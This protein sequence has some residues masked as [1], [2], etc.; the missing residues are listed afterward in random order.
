MS[1]SPIDSTKSRRT[2]ERSHKRRSSSSSIRVSIEKKSRSR[3]SS[4]RYRPRSHIRSDSQSRPY[5]HRPKVDPND[6]ARLN[7]ARNPVLAVF[8]LD[9][10]ATKEDLYR[11]YSKYGCT[12][13][14]V[15]ID[16]ITGNPRGIGFVYFRSTEDSRRA[17]RDTHGIFILERKIRVDYSIG[18]NPSR[19][20]D[21]RYDN[22]RIEEDRHQRD[23]HRTEYYSDRMYQES[24]NRYDDRHHRDYS[25][26]ESTRQRTPS[27]PIHGSR[28]SRD[29]FQDFRVTRPRSRSISPDR[30]RRPEHR[31]RR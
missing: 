13:C 4:P 25:R 24:L 3:S 23:R 10:N 20:D 31:Y 26:H 27:T 8:G 11:V 14:K 18:D 29:S 21:D 22:R 12:R 6:P 15:I 19:Y 28:Y 2:P 17:K 9:R 30:H 16:R 7:P 5:N 1:N